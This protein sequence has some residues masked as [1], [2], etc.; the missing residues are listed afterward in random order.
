MPP[1]RG[2][3]PGRAPETPAGRAEIMPQSCPSQSSPGL[4]GK[5]LKTSVCIGIFPE[6]G[7]FMGLGELRPAGQA[8]TC[9]L[10]ATRSFTGSGSMPFAGRPGQM[11]S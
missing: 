9:T 4:A 6:T 8:L 3:P 7:T 10:C 5:F 2:N 11:V 1:C